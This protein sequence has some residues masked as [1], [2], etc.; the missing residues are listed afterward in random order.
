[1]SDRDIIGSISNEPMITGQMEQPLVIQGTMEARFPANVWVVSPLL[2]DRTGGNYT[3][4]FD[5]NA[6]LSS[7]SSNGYMR[8]PTSAVDGHFPQ[9]DGATGNLV[10][11]GKAAPSGVV[12]GTTDTQTL[13]NKTLTSPAITTPTGLVKGDVGLGNV[14][15]TSDATKNAAVAT[16]TNKTLTS[17]VINSPTG[18]V[19]AD[20]GLGNVD[21]TSDATKNAAAVSLTNKNLTSGTN[22]FPTLNQNTTGSAATLTTSRN[23]DGQA[24]N[25]SADITVIAPGTHAATSK[26]TPVD[27]DELPLVDS[28]A[29]N[30][31]KKL[32]WANLKAALSGGG[33]FSTP[34]GRLTLTSGVAVTTSDVTGATSIYWTPMGGAYPVWDGSKFVMRTV[35]ELT[36]AL[37][38]TSGHAGYH[39]SGKNFDLFLINDSGTDRLV[40]GPAW[41]L[42]TSRGT[43]AGTT[44][45]DFSKSGLPTNKNSM[46][47]RFGSGSGD[48][49]SVPA[50]Q[51]TCVGFFRATA[52]GRASDTAW[53]RLLYN[54]YNQAPR[55]L[56]RGQT[57]N[58][59]SYGG[60]GEGVWRYSNNDATQRIEVLCGDASEVKAFNN[61]ILVGGDTTFRP[62][63]IGIGLDSSSSIANTQSGYIN[64]HNLFAASF[65]SNYEG[66]PGLGWHYFS[67]LEKGGGV[68]AAT[69]FGTNSGAASWKTGISGSVLN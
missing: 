63:E 32:T 47:V 30:V 42:D 28:A 26:T 52:D 13:T 67:N 57:A 27:A 29:S 33:G 11:D 16:L 41:S 39:Q 12:V 19:K 23:I 45:L 56:S 44:E 49:V 55:P 3:F 58:S 9:F 53:K 22:T 59:W 5:M 36:L 18:I 10:K 46:I 4:S 1:M 17:P 43:G 50:N 35:A 61:A 60:A 62:A 64:V 48:T 69:W 15:N 65:Q 2:L 24:F 21:N 25:G 31:L 66:C 37:D 20:V 14:D 38:A 54:L 6:V 40:T 8:G 34:Q 68:T 7:V 51:A